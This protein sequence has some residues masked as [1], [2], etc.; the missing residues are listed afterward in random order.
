MERGDLVVVKIGGVECLAGEEPFH[1]ADVRLRKAEFFQAGGIRRE[2]VAYGRHDQRAAAQ[3]L[4]VVCDVARA[5]AVFAAHFR[6][7]KRDVENVDLFGEDV[8]LE[9]IL[10]YHDGVVSHRTANQ[11]VH[12]NIDILVRLQTCRL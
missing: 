12:W 9:L 2:V 10:E 11:C 7:Q 8:I 5:S 3:H 1:M 6:Y 4:Q